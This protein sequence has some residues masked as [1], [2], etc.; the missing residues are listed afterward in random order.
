MDDLDVEDLIEEETCVFTLTAAGYIKRTPVSTY[1]AQRRGGKGI[2][3]QSLKEEDYVESV[4]TASTVAQEPV[5]V[6]NP[7]FKLLVLGLQLLPIEP[8][9]GNQ[10]HIADGL[11]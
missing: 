11:H 1:R 3:A 6:G 8:L 4:F 10:A 9:E 5:K 2:T 7:L